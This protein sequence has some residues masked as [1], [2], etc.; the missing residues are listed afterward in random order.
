MTNLYTISE[1]AIIIPSLNPNQELIALLHQLRKLCDN[2]IIVINDGSKGEYQNIFDEVTK[3]DGVILLRHCINLGKGRALKTAFN[4]FLNNRPNGIGVVTADADGQHSPTDICKCVEM[5]KNSPESLILGCREFSGENVPWKSKLGNNLTISAFKILGG[6]SIRD[7]QTGLRGIPAHFM[8][9]IMDVSGERFEFET[10]MLLETHSVGKKINIIQFPIQTVYIDSNR[11]THFR[12]VIDSLKIYRVIFKSFFHR[13]FLFI[14][15]GL[16]SAI[17]DQ[18][19]FAALFYK[20]IPVINL[21]PLISSVVIARI[22]SLLFNYVVNRNVVFGCKGKI[23]ESKS[24]FSYLLLCIFVM[25]S[26]YFLLKFAIFIL[27]AI[28]ILV[29]KIIIDTM[30]FISNYY[31][32]KHWCFRRR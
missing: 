30:L 3:I 14:V 2:T 15:S 6:I 29:L 17:I 5:L 11:E 18:G 13:F 26:S 32:Q 24:F 12:P 16:L 28:N 8:Y 21:P 9:Q 25:F 31:L 4:F 7:T 19:L 22:V 23:F 27:P 1:V 20:V 10:M